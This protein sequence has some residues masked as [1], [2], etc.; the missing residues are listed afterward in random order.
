MVSGRRNVAVENSADWVFNRIADVYSERPPYPPALVDSIAE[1]APAG[2]RVLELGAG[3]GHLAIPL[4]ERGLCVT[5]V[6][7]A[8]AMLARLRASAAK[9][10]VALAACHATAEAL[11]LHAGS[12][13]LVIVADAL[14][15][16]NLELAAPEVARVLDARGGLAIV[17][18][19][20][21]DTAFMRGI[22]RIMQQA[23]P[24]RPR[25]VAKAIAQ[26]ASIVGVA[27]SPQRPPRVFEDRTPVQ[28]A[29]L[30]AILRSISFIGPA[31]NPVRFADFRTQIHALDDAP[32]WARSFE[33][34]RFVTEAGARRRR[35]RR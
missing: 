22:S 25:A 8:A 13:D 10:R 17:T 3:I 5:A 15:F 9:R 24:R 27:P 20:F 11:P 23:A 2:G 34:H 33:L 21:A 19:G 1:L 26:L 18:C 35:P 29:Q 6:E 28:P 4:A 31:M 16:L 14:H 32:V 30:E 7:P 12:Q